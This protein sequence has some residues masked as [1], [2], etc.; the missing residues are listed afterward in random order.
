[1][2][3]NVDVAPV[4]YES[5][6][7]ITLSAAIEL[8]F[9]PKHGK[10]ITG[11]EWEK[12]T[13]RHLK[14]VLDFLGDGPVNELRHGHYKALWRQL[15]QEYVDNGRYGPRAAEMILTTLATLVRWLADEERIPP[16]V[17]LPPEKW[18][19]L[20]RQDWEARV[21]API[22]E[23]KKLRYTVEEQQALWS[24]L[25][26]ADPRMGLLVEIGAERRL[27]QVARAM[28]SDIAKHGSRHI[29]A[30]TIHG[31]GKKRGGYIVFTEQQRAWVR[32]ALFEGHLRDVE[33][34]YRAGALRD[35]FLA[36]G[37]FLKADRV[38]LKNA[39]RPA[40]F[41]ALRTWWMDLEKLAGVE[42]IEGRCW[43]GLRR[44]AADTSEDIEKD[45]RVLRYEGGW[46]EDTTRIG[47]QERERMLIAE[48]AAAM[49]AARRPKLSVVA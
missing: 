17:G 28:R 43:Y 6:P 4:L 48:R 24:V 41:R 31:K 26:L 11:S 15:A 38:Q 10:Y 1:M 36:P 34:A 8:A 45:A 5:A 40:S 42:H 16:N 39:L 32:H 44:L 7:P 37:M 29:G 25:H 46:T 47:Y 30:I 33:R 20:M 9:D 14:I 12:D 2:S 23:P 21:G 49:R 35:Y 19:K 3:W 18:L 22:P 27:G 13:R